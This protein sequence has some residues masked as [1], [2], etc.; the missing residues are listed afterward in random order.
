MRVNGP[1]ACRAV[2]LGAS[3][4]EQDGFAHLQGLAG[5]R[6]T[7]FE[8]ATGGHRTD[9]IAARVAGEVVPLAPRFCVVDAGGNDAL[10]DIPAATVIANLQGIYDEL[11][12]ANIQPLACTIQPF[13]N[14]AGWT[15][16]RENIRAEIEAFVNASP[17]RVMSYSAAIGDGENPPGVATQYD[18]GDGL[19]VNVAGR[20]AISREA[21]KAFFD[22]GV[23]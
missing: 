13:A 12:E 17:F 9:Q 18:A 14:Y 10:Q 8:I 20:L 3:F 16:G 6:I 15:Q 7:W 21:H 11:L 22:G 23:Y 5:G 19:H 2:A 1:T 4:V